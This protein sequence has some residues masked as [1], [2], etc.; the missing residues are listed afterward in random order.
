MFYEKKKIH[1]IFNA[2]ME[3]LI[4][5]ENF[6]KLDTRKQEILSFKLILNLTYFIRI[7]VTY[8]EAELTSLAR[9]YGMFM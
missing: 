9:R 6:K 3:L 7:G 8:T 2:L 4:N 5:V 1:G